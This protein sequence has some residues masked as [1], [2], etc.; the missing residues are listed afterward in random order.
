MSTAY[1]LF[2][3][4]SEAVFIN[5][6]MAQQLCVDSAAALLRTS[7]CAGKIDI[8]SALGLDY[9][10]CWDLKNLSYSLAIYAS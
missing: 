6:V 3:K 10:T 5:V 1:V 9:R 4:V 7:V 2:L 8:L